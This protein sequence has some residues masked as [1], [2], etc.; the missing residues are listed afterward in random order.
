M[1]VTQAAAGLNDIFNKMQLG[2]TAVVTEDLSNLVDV[3]KVVVDYLTNTNDFDNFTKQMIDM[4]GKTIYWDRPYTS[5]APN[6]L[7]DSW[8]FGSILQKVRCNLMKARDAA[9]WNL[10]ADSQN[11]T[12][13]D[14]FELAPPSVKA[15]FFNKAVTFEV[16]ITLAEA[17]IKEAFRSAQDMMRF[18][19]MIE[20]RVQM[21]LTLCMDALVMATICN[22]MGQKIA[23]NEN[24]V[25]LVKE[26]NTFINASPA[27]TK[28]DCV[29]DPDFWRFVSMMLGR[30]QNYLE[31]ASSLYNHGD[32]VTFTP[33]DKQKF[34]MLGDYAKAMETWLYSNTYHDDYVKVNGYDTVGFWQGTGSTAPGAD[35]YK[36]NVGT[37][38]EVSGSAVYKVVSADVLGTIFD[39]EAAV[40][41]CEESNV[42]SIYNPRQRYWNYFYQKFVKLINDVE[43]NC[44]VFTMNDTATPVVTYTGVAGA[45][46]SFIIPN[47]IADDTALLVQYPAWDTTYAVS[48]STYYMFDPEEGTLEQM[49]ADD[50]TTATGW[51][52]TDYYGKVVVKLDS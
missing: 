16:P 29:K 26:Y 21:K 36:V 32:Y 30:Y 8:E 24:V 52:V 51:D 31:S 17:Q 11:G 19:A 41:C 5:A 38:I 37:E 12:Y 18:I 4:V 6:L 44:V 3:G 27:K 14:P 20:N 43:E 2:E 39:E 15:K 46:G 1:K 45:D 48:S 23:Y 49:T 34:I 47:T 9:P 28:A 7:K 10:Y 22:L 42:G 50:A 13:A 25:N 40:L 35:R 33:K